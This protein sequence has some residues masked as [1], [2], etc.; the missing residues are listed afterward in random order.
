MKLLEF[1][2]YFFFEHRTHITQNQQNA[3]ELYIYIMKMKNR[4]TL[5]SGNNG[6]ITT[7]YNKSS[8]TK[9]IFS[10]SMDF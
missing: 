3:Q 6:N 5:V 4:K 1:V 7:E 2:G 8:E 9:I 10:N